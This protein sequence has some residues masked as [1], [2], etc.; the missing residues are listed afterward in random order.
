MAAGC[1]TYEQ[2]R[3]RIRCLAMQQYA[4]LDAARVRIKM[5][6][7]EER[8]APYLLDV[9]A[10]ES[11][12]RS[13]ETGGRGNIA[14]AVKAVY[15]AARPLANKDISGRVRRYAR[16]AHADERTI[17]RWLREARSLCAAY[18]GLSP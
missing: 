5:E 2:E 18:R 7:A 3:D 9:L 16:E 11:T 8:A 12:M 1:P 10:A 17:Y 13:L 6:Q 15:G 4:H 14:A